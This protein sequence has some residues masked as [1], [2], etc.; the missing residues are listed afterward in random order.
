MRLSRY[1]LPTLKEDPKEAQI[2]SHRL[3]LRAGMIQQSSAGI[4]SWLPMGFKVMKKIE[5]I[6]REEQNRVGALEILMPTLQPADLWRESGRYDD[7][8]KEMLRITDRHERD[9]LY[10]PTNEEQVT[11]IF[12]SHVKSYKN[13]P[14]N[15]YHIQWKFRDEVRPRFGIMRG[16]EFLMKDAYS[17][18]LDY[19]GAKTAYNN[20]FV[21]YLKTFARLGVKAIPLRAA[22]GPIGGD[23]SH[24]FI[25]LADTGESEV[26]YH[27]DI[28]TL[29]TPSEA[30]YSAEE[31]QGIVDKWTSYYAAAD[32]MH[33]PATCDID[34]ADL[35]TRRGIEVGH[36]FHFGDKYSKAM[37]ATVAGPEGKDVTVSMGSYGIGVSRLVGGI[38]EASHD[39][40]GIIWPESVAPFKVGLINL[41]SGDEA[42]DAACE[43]FYNKLR[44]QD[45]D[46]LNDDTSG[47]AGEKFANMDL[48]GLPWQA[49]IGPRGVKSGIVEVKNRATGEKQELGLD[50]A[51]QLLVGLN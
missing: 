32:D 24:E 36:I 20:M 16:R 22:T 14:L 28:L 26:F 6:V 3:M 48:I 39:D 30:S 33:D 11:D 44:N 19:E 8:G 21:A 13:L 50:D 4:Y 51:L 17:F 47:R 35:V 5:Q 9:M 29:E 37:G 1:F 12:R 46:V 43:D 25:V 27:K 42:C 31:L 15:L 18:D 45:I 34:D 49:T 23:L 40:A 41:K 7:Y 38:I 10:G 2:V